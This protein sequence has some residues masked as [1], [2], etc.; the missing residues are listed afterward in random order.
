M[1]WTTKQLLA[2]EDEA[3]TSFEKKLENEAIFNQH[4]ERD[5]DEAACLRED[6]GL[7]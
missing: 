2:R 7:E 3:T 5:L 4:T 1:K 6:M